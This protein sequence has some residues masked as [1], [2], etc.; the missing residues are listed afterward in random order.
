MSHIMFPIYKTPMNNLF[1]EDFF[2]DMIF[3]DINRFNV[4][5][6]MP[7]PGLKSAFPGMIEIYT[8]H[9]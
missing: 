2:R 3:Y 7:A 9:H 6:E 1:K 5:L 8:V 4:F